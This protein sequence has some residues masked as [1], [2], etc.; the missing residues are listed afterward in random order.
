MANYFYVK[1]GG[2]AIGSVSDATASD[3]IANT[4]LT[5]TF[6][7]LG[8]T[9]PKVEDVMLG[10][11]TPATGDFIVVSDSHIQTFS[12]IAWLGINVAGG[13]S[14]LT[15]LYAEDANCDTYSVLTATSL[16]ITGGF[17]SRQLHLFGAYFDFAKINPL[18]VNIT[19][20]QSS[21]YNDCIFE[22]T[23]GADDS[24]FLFSAVDAK[25]DYRNCEFI[26]NAGVTTQSVFGII[27]ISTVSL[28]NCKM[29][30]AGGWDSLVRAA[31]RPIRL[32]ASGC[33]FSAA[34]Q[35]IALS[36]GTVTSGTQKFRFD[37]CH[38][39]SSVVWV[40][41]TPANPSFRLEAYNCTNTTD[42]NPNQFFV[43]DYVGTAESIIEDGTALVV[44]TDG[45]EMA[46]ETSGDYMSCKVITNTHCGRHYPFT[47]EM[48]V[49]WSALSAAATDTIRLF[50]TGPSGLT[51][52]DVMATVS[53]RDGTTKAQINTLYSADFD[54][55]G[56][57][58]A[59]TSDGTST[60]TNAGALTKY[61]IDLDTSIDAGIDQYPIVTI[62]VRKP[63]ITVY[64]DTEY[65]LVA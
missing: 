40:E 59:L 16:T 38:V 47:F 3:G 50:L 29:S 22:N 36:G 44:R 37:N 34:T 33:D 56:A 46:M 25:V 4:K 32:K 42:D 54:P 63:S 65:E 1:A 31:T 19:E 60:W 64:F 35:I 7:S 14:Y 15:M 52:A 58:V 55:I 51:D 53:Y 12:A 41:E 49:T 45:S 10:T 21:S 48:P 24:M 43:Q 39:K 18:N 27:N 23:S 2:T 13:A 30:G 6:A 17:F 28:E 5:G 57:G 61:Q 20:Q 62:H 9:F 8:D 26:S 11:V